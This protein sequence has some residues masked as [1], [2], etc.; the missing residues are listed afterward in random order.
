MSFIISSEFELM[1]R[2]ILVIVYFF[3]YKSFHISNNLLKSVINFFIMGNT[4]NLFFK[5]LF[6][7]ELFV[8]C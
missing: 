5:I 7:N 4:D 6:F 1:V 3:I 8:N 2:S